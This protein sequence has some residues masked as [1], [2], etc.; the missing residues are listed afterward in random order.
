M[1][2]LQSLRLCVDV[3]QP[4]VRAR[5]RSPPLL[6]PLFG[7]AAQLRELH[8]LQAES[9]RVQAIG[10]AVEM[11]DERAF[12]RARRGDFQR[13]QALTSC[14]LRYGSRVRSTVGM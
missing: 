9:P 13:V 11:L 4:A 12:Q 6:K 1:H 10:E 5:R 2:R 3:L 8:G 7:L 14:V